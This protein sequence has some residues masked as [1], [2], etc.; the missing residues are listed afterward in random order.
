MAETNLFVVVSKIVFTRIVAF[1][2]GKTILDYLK[3]RI[4][5]RQKDEACN[6]QKEEKVE[7]MLE[8]LLRG[9][10]GTIVDDSFDKI[11]EQEQDD[12]EEKEVSSI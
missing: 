11:Q 12:N 7:D 4:Y 6:L 9:E 10:D 8:L 3:E 5:R 1:K 2:T